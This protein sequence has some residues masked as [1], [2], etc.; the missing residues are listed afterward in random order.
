MKV[1]EGNVASPLGFSADGLHAGFKKRKLDFGWI[2]SE[3]P[4]SVA[5]VYTTNKVIAAPL[6]VTRQS[7]KKAQKMKAIVVNSGIANSCTGVQGMEDA[8][9]MQKWTAEK[10]GVEPDLVGVASTGVIGDLLPMDTLKTGLSKLVVNG[11]SDDFSKAILTT[12]TM[13]KT[14][15]VTEKFGRDEVTM[16]GVAKGSGMIHPNMAT[17]LAFI[18]CDANISSETLQL[19]L[20][21]NVETTF[22]QITV[23]GDTSTN[24]MVLVMSNGCILNEEILPNTPEFDKFSAM[25]NYVMQEL[26]KMIAKD[27]EGASKLIEVN[28]K[29]APNALDARMIAKSVVGSSLVKT[30]IFGEDPNWGRIL[31]AVGYAGVDVPVDNIDIFLGDVRVMLKSSPVE[32]EAEEIQDVMHEDEITITVDLHAGEAQGKAWGC[33]LSYSYV[34]INALYRT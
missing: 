16:A 14:V 13:V 17:M 30:A 29:N 32:F 10:L 23:D 26:A 4:A 2:V 22:N 24:D 20:S 12:D 28:V 5:G 27:G 25:L 9:T 3:V 21:Q 7:V 33:D 34:K 15:A 31:A 19:A 6:I 11:N 18:T 1:I 8:Y